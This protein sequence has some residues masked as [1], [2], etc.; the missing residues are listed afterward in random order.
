MAGLR[1]IPGHFVQINTRKKQMK[2][3]LPG[4]PMNNKPFVAGNALEFTNIEVST[5][6]NSA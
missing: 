1:Q 5:N 6:T 2:S 4:Y 3:T